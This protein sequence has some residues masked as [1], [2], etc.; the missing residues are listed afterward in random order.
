LKNI[1]VQ[2]LKCIA[3]TIVL[4]SLFSMTA[5]GRPPSFAKGKK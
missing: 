4:G 3:K 1:V 2:M 5:H